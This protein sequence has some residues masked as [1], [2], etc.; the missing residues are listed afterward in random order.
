MCGC[1]LWVLY[2]LFYSFFRL[3]SFP[4]FVFYYL[5]SLCSCHPYPRTRIWWHKAVR[6]ENTAALI[7]KAF[8]HLFAF[9]F[10]SFVSVFLLE[11]RFWRLFREVKDLLD[12]F[13]F[14]LHFH[15][16]QCH[17]SCLPYEIVRLCWNSYLPC[18]E[19]KHVFL[20]VSWHC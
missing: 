9:Y 5:H 3:L 12:I 14:S 10:F 7:T 11:F 6:W 13:L 17:L 20:F 2:T 4:S 8:F 19:D 1:N 18:K 16:C 15:F